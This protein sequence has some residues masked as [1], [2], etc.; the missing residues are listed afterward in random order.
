MFLKAYVVWEFVRR[1]YFVVLRKHQAKYLN[2]VCCLSKVCL[3]FTRNLPELEV[4]DSTSLMTEAFRETW[5]FSYCCRDGSSFPADDSETSCLL[6]FVCISVSDLNNSNCQLRK[7]AVATRRKFMQW[8]P[9]EIENTFSRPL[10]VSLFSFLRKFIRENE[11]Q[12]SLFIAT[13]IPWN[14]YDRRSEASLF[15]LR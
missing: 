11:L 2:L 4:A 6:L 13:S 7:S 12:L 10:L 1:R 8:L 14:Y 15:S 5:G 3:V 9:C